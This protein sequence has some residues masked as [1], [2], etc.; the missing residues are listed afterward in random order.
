MIMEASKTP[1]PLILFSFIDKESVLSVIKIAE[2]SVSI[3]TL[4][5]DAMARRLNSR[6]KGLL[7]IIRDISA[8]APS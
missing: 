6:W 8:K 4:R 1:L 5:L 3:I 2:M 7:E